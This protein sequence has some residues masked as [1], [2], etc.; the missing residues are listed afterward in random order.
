MTFSDTHSS[1]FVMIFLLLCFAIIHSGGAALRVK[2]ES[3]IGARAWRLIFAFVSI[4]SAFILIGYFISHRYDGIRF[5][6]L[7]GVSELW[8][9]V[10]GLL[11]FF[12]MVEVMHTNYHRK[13]HPHCASEI[14]LAVKL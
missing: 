6:N 11:A 4:P 9:G 12:I 14:S 5:W 1:S 7:Q 10:Y 2:A 3:L 13:A 8:L